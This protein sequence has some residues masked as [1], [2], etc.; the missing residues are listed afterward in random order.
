M[1]ASQGAE[2]ERVGPSRLPSML[3]SRLRASRVNRES[4]GLIRLWKSVEKS[5]PEPLH[6]PRGYGTRSVP[7]SGG[8]PPAQ[9]VIFP[10]PTVGTLARWVVSAS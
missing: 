5:K 8:S 9:F 2:L 10:I 1:G 7:S 4:C 3:P 6:N